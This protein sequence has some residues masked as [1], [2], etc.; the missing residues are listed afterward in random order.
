MADAVLIALLAMIGVLGSAF[1]AGGI[2]LVLSLAKNRQQN[3]LLYLWNRQLVDHIYRGYPPPPPE[4]PEGLF[5][6]P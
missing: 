3:H 2:T 4:P 6:N 5:G 1:V